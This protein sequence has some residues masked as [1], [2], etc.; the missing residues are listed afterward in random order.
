MGTD[1]SDEGVKIWL[2]GYYKFQTSE[3]IVVYFPTGG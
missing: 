1:S 2:S 3:K